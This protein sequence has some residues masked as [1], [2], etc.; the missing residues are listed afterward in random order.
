MNKKTYQQPIMAN[1]EAW[2][3]MPIAEIVVDSGKENDEQWSKEREDE[4][5]IYDED[6]LGYSN[7]W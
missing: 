3:N 4:M 2:I 6:T 7:L 5:C 1:Q